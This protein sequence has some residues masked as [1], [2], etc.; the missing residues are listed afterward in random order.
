MGKFNLVFKAA[1]AAAACMIFAAGFAEANAAAAQAPRFHASA[2]EEKPVL[3]HDGAGK[4]GLRPSAYSV[5]GS[6]FSVSGASLP[7]SYR[8]KTTDVKD[9]GVYNTCWAFSNIATLESFLLKEGR[10]SYDLSENHLAWWSTAEYNSDGKGW[11]FDDLYYGGYSMIGAG[12]LTSWQGAVLEEDCPYDQYF[13]TLP[14]DMEGGTMPFNVTGIMYVAND[15]DSVKSAIYKYGAVATSYNSDDNN[16][17]I[18]KKAYYQ[19]DYDY[20]SGHAISIIGWDDNYSKRNFRK[21]P[22]KDG[23]WLVKNSWGEDMCDNGFMWIS[24]YDAM[25]LDTNTWGSNV[26]ITSARRNTGYDRLYQNEIY[27]ATWYTAINDEYDNPFNELTFVNV[28]DFDDT[29]KYLQKVIFETRNTGVKYTAYYIPVV[30]GVPDTNRDN[31]VTLASGRSSFSGYICV[32]TGSFR[33]PAGVGA[34]G[35]TMDSGDGYLGASIGVSEWVS[36]ENNVFMFMSDAKYGEG[37]V[38]IGSEVFDIMEVYSW[39]KDS[40]GGNIVLKAVA[41]EHCIGDVTGDGYSTT[42]DALCILRGSVKLT[43]FDAEQTINAD[44]NFDGNI[45]AAD[46]LLVQ[47]K[48]VGLISDY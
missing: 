44:T 1:C 4:N 18:G 29:H 42:A 22:P 10:G 24:Y 3:K 47:R 30:D 6:V 26:V 14:D 12:Y 17:N 19:S 37:F 35:V 45:T 2:V 46:S 41:S 31:W 13:N 39:A 5:E 7:S 36:D 8:S 32:D 15:I 11:L 27:G 38:I 33:V 48:A 16:Y 9:Q 28:F 23:A 40:I 25:L 21:I 34:I 20:S 43:G